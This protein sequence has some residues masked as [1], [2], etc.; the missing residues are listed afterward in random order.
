[1]N[2]AESQRLL[3]AETVRGLGSKVVFNYDDIQER[4][5][6]YLETVRQ[7]ARQLII[8]AQ[9]EAEGI[10]EKAFAEAKALGEKAGVERGEQELRRRIDEAAEKKVADRLGTALPALQ[11][12][13]TA[14]STERDRWLTHWQSAAIG[15]SVAIAEKIL[16]A[17]LGRRPELSEKIILGALQLAAGSPQIRLRLNPQD[18]Q[19]FG[20][21]CEEI[22]RN[23]A[24]AGSATL[25]EDAGIT[26]GGC[27]IDTQH[28]VIDAQL[29]SQLAR[30]ASELLEQTI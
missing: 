6:T 3:K 30:I 20:R 21:Q 26:P 28:G 18:I 5:D 1:M 19:L 10:R 14:L 27:V 9:A 12:A 15:L 13:A 24:S 7:Q 23:M 29:E 4:C 17:E 22:I 16:H 2:S 11:T 25:T 8:D